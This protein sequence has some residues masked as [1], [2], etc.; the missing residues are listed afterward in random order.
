MRRWDI[1]YTNEVYWQGIIPLSHRRLVLKYSHDIK[2][3]RHLGIKKT[4]SKI[5]QNYYWPGLQNDVK[6]Y[7]GGCDICARRKEPLKTKKAPM[8]I[9]KSGFPMERIAIDILGELPITERGNRYILVVGDYFTKWTE[10][11]VMPNMEASTV[12]SI[13]VE[14]VV[15]RFGIPYF[16]HSDQGRQF[17]SKLFS[18]MCKLLQITKIRTTPYHPKSDGM[19]ERFNKTLTAMLSAFVNENHTKWDEQLQSVMMAYRSTEHETTGLTP[20][21]CMLGRETT[22]PL[23]IMYEMPP[24]IKNIPQNMWVWKLQENLEM[25]HAKVRQNISDNMIRQ[26]RYHDENLSFETFEA[27]DKVYVYFPVKKVGCFSKLTSYWRGPYQ[28]FDKLSDS[29]YKINCGKKGQFQVTHCDRLSKAKQQVLAREDNVVVED[30]EI[31]EP[32]PSMHDSGYEVD[33]SEE[34]RVRRKPEWM[35]NYIFFCRRQK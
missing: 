8:E 17:E 28:V 32:L 11:Y 21:M 15:S 35:K 34:R 20:N 3:S 1:L 18:E 13:L 4:L 25:A 10:C 16:I 5:R 9:V 31:S 23:D 19:V 7:M 12:A 33:Y 6:A 30:I 14:Q 27:G 22:C 24:A 29:L 2:A 26:K